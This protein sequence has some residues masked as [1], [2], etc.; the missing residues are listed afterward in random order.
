MV[1]RSGFALAAVIAF[2]CGPLRG[3]DVA[4]DDAAREQ[5]AALFAEGRALLDRDPTAACGK[6]EAA[7]ALD[8][9]AP[10]T[11]LNLGL[12]Y[13]RLDKLATSLYWFRKALVAAAEANLPDSEEAAKQR[14]SALAARVATMRID[15]SQAPAD[16]QVTLDGRL[17]SRTDFARVEVN[18]GTN[19]L[20]ASAAGMKPFRKAIEVTA[21]DH[22]T[23]VIV[24]ERAA[25]PGAAAAPGRGRRITAYVLGGVGVALVATSGIYAKR[26]YDAY[27]DDPNKTD[28]ARDDAA[29]KLDIGT[30]IFIAGAAA[31]G[32]GVILYVTAPKAARPERRDATAVV[33]LVAP[34]QLGLAVS[35]AF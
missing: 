26:A 29:R 34:T 19:L 31:I 10:G 6:F 25:A 5:A 35:G 28:A 18:A 3:G 8:P 9:T 12:C 16:V 21:R 32:A 23:E 11:L 7:I 17:V 30:G 33:P 27:N 20:E 14:T 24:L 13:E 4:A 15:A 22:G 1:R 2:L